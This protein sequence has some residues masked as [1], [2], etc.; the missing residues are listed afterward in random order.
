V[1]PE[2]GQSHVAR[3]NRNIEA[4]Q[5]QSQFAG[6]LRL[7][8]GRVSVYEK[9]LQAFM[10]ETEYRHAMIVTRNA[11]GYKRTKSLSTEC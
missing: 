3:L 1:Q 10:S 5:D 2:A 9:T 8:F 11:S 4:A 6:M 7:D